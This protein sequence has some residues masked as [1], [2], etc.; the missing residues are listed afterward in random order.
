MTRIIDSVRA[1]EAAIKRDAGE[2][3]STGS[4]AIAAIKAG[5]GTPEWQTYMEQFAGLDSHQL[6]RL[7]AEDGTLGDEIQDKKRAYLVGNGVCGIQSPNT[8]NLDF[9][10]NTID[11]GLPDVACDPAF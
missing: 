7:L 5:I 9:T 4:L 2:A 11:E 8:Q 6:K 1:R 10:V 3:H